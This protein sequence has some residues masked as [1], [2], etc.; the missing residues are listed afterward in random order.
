MEKNKVEPGKT[1]TVGGRKLKEGMGDKT[2]I[3]LL[4]NKSRKR[5]LAFAVTRYTNN[6]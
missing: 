4:P 6:E 3:H 2:S 5:S 1:R